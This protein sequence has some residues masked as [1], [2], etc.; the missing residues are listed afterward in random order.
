MSERTS[1]KRHD[2]VATAK[3]QHTKTHL[4]GAK[5]EMT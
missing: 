5:R 4:A 2:G 3:V 1:E